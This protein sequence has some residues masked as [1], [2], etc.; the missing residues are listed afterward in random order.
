M[1]VIEVWRAKQV[2][3]L[4][5]TMGAGYAGGRG[6][7]CSI[8]SCLHDWCSDVCSGRQH[9]TVRLCVGLSGAGADN[10]VFYKPNTCMLLGDA[11]AVC[12]QLVAAVA[13]QQSA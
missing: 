10:P 3:I 6:G 8:S 12:Q 13:E 7:V 1:P 9:S 5:R 11:K 4:K 2:I